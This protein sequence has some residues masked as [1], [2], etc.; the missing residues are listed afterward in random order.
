MEQF[1]SYFFLYFLLN[2]CFKADALEKDQA[3]LTIINASLASSNTTRTES[4][5]VSTDTSLTSLVF[6]DNLRS[7]DK[8]G[9]GE[10]SDRDR[11]SISRF[12]FN[13]LE[14]FSNQKN[15]G[16]KGLEDEKDWKSKM[17]KLSGLLDGGEEP[18]MWLLTEIGKNDLWRY[19]GLLRNASLN[20]NRLELISTRRQC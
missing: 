7:K 3:N 14:I 18:K 6:I 8:V 2:L 9:E 20:K 10:L 12:N 11:D 4:R 5:N 15:P 1:V 17:A 13:N 19:L 16:Q